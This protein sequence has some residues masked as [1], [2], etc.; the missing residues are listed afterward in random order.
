MIS[1]HARHSAC[2]IFT[3]LNKML[4]DYLINLFFCSFF[5]FCCCC[6]FPVSYPSENKQKFPFS[7]RK[8]NFSRRISRRR[9][10][11]ENVSFLHKSAFMLRYIAFCS[12]EQFISCLR[13]EFHLSVTEMFYNWLYLSS[14]AERHRRNEWRDRIRTKFVHIQ[15]PSTQRCWWTRTQDLSGIKYR[16][17]ILNHHQNEKWNL[18]KSVTGISVST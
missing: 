1:L 13:K 14:S 18:R 12:A 10:C 3:H 8:K 16:T 7:E 11:R 9:Y 15:L 17:V 4:W 6:V 2:L 5:L